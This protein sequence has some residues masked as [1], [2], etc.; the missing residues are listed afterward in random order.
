MTFTIKTLVNRVRE[1]AMAHPDRQAD[2][3]YYCP[4]HTP[5]CIMG[6]ALTDLGVTY[7]QMREC[8]RGTT[9]PRGYSLGNVERD[10]FHVAVDLIDKNISHAEHNWGMWL[11][12]VQEFQDNGRSWQQAVRE[13]DAFYAKEADDWND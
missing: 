6:H 12:K 2:C 8:H 10:V 1:L 7:E 3:F 4:D 11:N 9:L 13:A 5:N